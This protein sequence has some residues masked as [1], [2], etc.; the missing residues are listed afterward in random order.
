MTQEEIG[1][2]RAP[3]ELKSPDQHSGHCQLQ[4]EGCIRTALPIPFLFLIL[5]SRRYTH[6]PQLT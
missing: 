5:A 4:S 1:F 6:M 2:G 3:S